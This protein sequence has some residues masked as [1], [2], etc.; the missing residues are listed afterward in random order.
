MYKNI[1]VDI[2]IDNSYPGMYIMKNIYRKSALI[3]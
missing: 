2:C 3:L 1:C